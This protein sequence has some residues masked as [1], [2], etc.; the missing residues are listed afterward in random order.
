MLAPK[1]SSVLLLR[2]SDNDNDND[3]DDNDDVEEEERENE[4]VETFSLFSLRYGEGRFR[5]PKEGCNVR[6]NAHQRLFEITFQIE[7]KYPVSFDQ[8]TYLMMTSA[9]IPYPQTLCRPQ[10]FLFRVARFTFFIFFFVLR[11]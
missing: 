8:R 6:T 9:P 10:P 11:S 4:E 5:L 3:N 7:D 2:V 1:S